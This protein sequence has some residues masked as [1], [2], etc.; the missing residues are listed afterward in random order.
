[1]NTGRIASNRKSISCKILYKHNFFLNPRPGKTNNVM[2]K[3]H[4]A[5]LLLDI[6]LDFVRIVCFLSL[7]IILM[8]HNSG[9]IGVSVPQ[10]KWAMLSVGQEVE[11]RT[12]TF[13]KSRSYIS[14]VY[15]V[16]IYF[17]IDCG[18][19]ISVFSKFY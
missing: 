1:M 19:S 14:Q 6:F 4:S 11:I 18:N 8:I 12:Y 2:W 3:F 9:E 15:I 10:R 16:N 13:D 5:K 7:R 17:F